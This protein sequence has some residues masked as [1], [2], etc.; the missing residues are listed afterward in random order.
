MKFVW[1]LA[2]AI[3]AAAAPP[4]MATDNPAAAPAPHVKITLLSPPDGAVIQQNNPASGCAFS[5]TRGYGLR[6]DFAWREGGHRHEVLA[7]R[8]VA[9][10]GASIPIVDV[11]IPDTT[12]TWVACDAFTQ[13]L[14]GWSWSVSALDAQSNV[15]GTAEGTFDFA[16]CELSDGTPC[17]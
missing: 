12:Y 7:Y 5:P 15:L 8:L 14:Q 2:L 13:L 11:T 10:L 3:C 6:I 16:P 9:A 4:A 17:S 1:I